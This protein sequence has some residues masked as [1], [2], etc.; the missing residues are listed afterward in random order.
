MNIW[1]WEFGSLGVWELVSWRV[2]ELMS[3]WVFD[4]A[5]WWVGGLVS[6]WVN[7]LVSWWSGEF[8]SWWVGEL[9]ILWLCD[10]VGLWVGYFLV[11]EVVTRWVDEV[12]SW[13]V[14][15]SGTLGF[16]EFIGKP[17]C[18][19][20]HFVYK[21]ECLCCVAPQGT[22]TSQFTETR[23]VETTSLSPQ[24]KHSTLGV[25]NNDVC[26]HSQ[27]FCLINIILTAF[28]CAKQ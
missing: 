13:R 3:L 7:E 1:V 5:G 16:R 10:F 19:V 14:M 11:N 24:S 9:V 4:F 2:F 8:L 12:E 27:P 22:H 26:K 21:E 28:H 6:V 17:S 18:V 23:K 15:Y 20:L 25:G